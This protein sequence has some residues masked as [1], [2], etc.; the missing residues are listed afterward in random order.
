M[1]IESQ[2]QLVSLGSGVLGVVAGS[3]GCF[4]VLRKQ[5][6]LGDAVSHAALP[7]IMLAFLLVR[8]K[9]PLPLVGGAAVAGWLAALLAPRITSSTRIPI[10]TALCGAMSVFF[11]LGILLQTYIQK[12]VSDARQA[13]LDKFLFGEAAL[14]LVADVRLMALLGGLAVLVMLIFWKEFKLL[15][16]DPAFAASL[17]RPVRALDVLLTSL[18]VAAIVIGLRSV[19]VVLMSALLV[20]PGAAARQWTDRLGRMVALAALFGGASGVAGTVVSDRWRHVPPGPTI[21]L[22]ATGIVVFSLLFAP[23]RGLVWRFFPIT[24]RAGRET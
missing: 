13:G 14:L 5:S 23:H 7:G 24:I 12:N 19:G 22:I 4:A 8:S 10:D 15:S 17:G 3:L 1:L 11:G 6:L 18:L 16:F 21:V 2:L 9:D 20:A